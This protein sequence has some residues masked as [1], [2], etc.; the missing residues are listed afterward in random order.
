MRLSSLQ[1]AALLKLAVIMDKAYG[2]KD[3]SALALQHYDA[4]TGEDLW[5]EYVVG[6]TGKHKQKVPID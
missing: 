1:P 4:K 5:T 3:L 2:S 6:L